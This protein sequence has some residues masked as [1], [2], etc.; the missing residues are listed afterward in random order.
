[1][2]KESIEF[3][4]LTR[5]DDEEKIKG[6]EKGRCTL[7]SIVVESSEESFDLIHQ[8]HTVTST[9]QQTANKTVFKNGTKGGT[10][11]R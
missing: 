9:N 3:A 4:A 8:P 11:G 6:D 10:F 7:H 2:I 1:M 5:N